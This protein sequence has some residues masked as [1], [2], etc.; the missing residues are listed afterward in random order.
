MSALTS[1]KSAVAEVGSTETQRLDGGRGWLARARG[2]LDLHRGAAVRR[3]S[4]EQMREQDLAPVLLIRM[5]RQPYTLSR[6][7][8]CQQ[9]TDD[10]DFLK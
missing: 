10:I 6:G 3:W 5:P 8:A 7:R 1:R 2:Q 4:A 9:Q